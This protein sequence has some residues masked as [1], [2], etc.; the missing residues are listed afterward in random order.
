MWQDFGGAVQEHACGNAHQGYR[1]SK[2][3][4]SMALSGQSNWQH[5]P[6]AGTF[7]WA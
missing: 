1:T 4:N 6:D 7:I 5:P 2:R 3:Q